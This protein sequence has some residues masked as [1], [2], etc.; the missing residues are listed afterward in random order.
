MIENIRKKA[1][2]LVGF[3]PTISL[4]RF[5]HIKVGSPQAVQSCV[6]YFELKTITF[7]LEGPI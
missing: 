3:E 2:D 1:Q 4:T 6:H 5:V 7:A